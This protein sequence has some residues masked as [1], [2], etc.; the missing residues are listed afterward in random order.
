M[1]KLVGYRLFQGVSGSHIL[2]GRFVSYRYRGLGLLGHNWL[3]GWM[4]IKPLLDG[5]GLFA[6]GAD[7]IDAWQK[8]LCFGHIGQIP[9]YML[10]SGPYASKFPVKHVVIFQVVQ[11]TIA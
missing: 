3:V 7:F 11:Q 5:A 8:F 10:A 1:F 9:A 6:G 2:R 4:A